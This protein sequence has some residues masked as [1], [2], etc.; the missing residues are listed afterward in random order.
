MLPS[1][2]VLAFVGITALP[3]VAQAEVDEA[4]VQEAEPTETFIVNGSTL[5]VLRET[6]SWSRLERERVERSDARSA[7]EVLQ[8]AP[9]ALV[10]TNSR[11]ET[12]VY[13]RNAGERQ[14]G[15]FLDGAPLAIPWDHR[16]DL[17]LIPALMIQELSVARGP[18]SNRYGP[19][20]SGGAVFVR[21]ASPRGGPSAQLQG[22]LGEAGAQRLQGLARFSQDSV[23]VVVGAE[24][25]NWDGEPLA[26]AAQLPFSQQGE[27][28]S[29]SDRERR[30]AFLKAE[31][32]LGNWALSLSALHG[33]TVAGV[34]PESHLDPEQTPPRYWR[35]PDSE[36]SMLIANAE[37][38]PATDWTLNVTGWFQR[39]NQ[40]I[41]SYGS[42]AYETVE[43]RQRDTN[44]SAGL[45][46]RLSWAPSLNHSVSAAAVFN[47]AVHR[48]Q[49]EPESAD[50]FS[51][52]SWSSGADYGFESRQLKLRV[53]GGVDALD[54]K[55]TA[56]RVSESRFLAWN[57][58]AG[59]RWTFE[60][61]AFLRAAAG[62]RARLPTM[63][64]LFG[65]ALDRFV[66]NPT[67]EPERNSTLELGAGLASLRAEVEA[68]A[69][70]R[71]T[72]DT[73]SQRIIDSGA[74]LRRQRVNL[75]TSSVL[76]IEFVAR[77]SPTPWLSLAGHGLLSRIRARDE[78][79]TQT[80]LGERP[81]LQGYG[82][83]VLG[84]PSLGPEIALEAFLRDRAYSLTSDGFERL[85][86]S[87]QF[88]VRVAYRFR[89]AAFVGLSVFARVDN[90]LDTTVV[91]QLGLPAP[92]RWIRAGL[93]LEFE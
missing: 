50:R 3:L 63:R 52:Q 48:E 42:E 65:V 80:F 49:I 60:N 25:N 43:E 17:A 67:L 6:E 14:V 76:G 51:N 62:S 47:T 55:D 20:V 34:I 38:D 7:A 61:S 90:I 5:S 70:A 21:S 30:S 22:E 19:N 44:R 32:E 40:D 13:L 91:P 77:A 31:S 72:D 53:G 15:I 78:D 37:G 41:D 79:G 71:R 74:E 86:G 27:L 89:P 8:R 11:G 58:S 75:G 85:P 73:L 16:V 35:T 29:N 92:G 9:G 26:S 82:T 59:A 10:Q 88:N 23:G 36:L 45:A 1:V 57:L 93:Q 69:F 66:P 12:L 28:R 39:F 18:L 84:D 87:T 2:L 24:L 56:G 4:S 46:T 54:P 33:R 64:E 68:I 81:E 83:L